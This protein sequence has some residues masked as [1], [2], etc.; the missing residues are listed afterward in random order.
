MLFSN[1]MTTGDLAL[2]CR[3]AR[4]SRDT[5]DSV[6]DT[7]TRN[8]MPQLQ[9]TCTKENSSRPGQVQQLH[10]A[11]FSKAPPWGDHLH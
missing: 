1:E 8:Q 3:N 7:S 6:T 2:A 11:D 4:D 5:A 10:L 9:R